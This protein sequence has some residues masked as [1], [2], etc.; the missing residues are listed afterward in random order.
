MLEKTGIGLSIFVIIIKGVLF[1][2]TQQTTAFDSAVN[3]IKTSKAIQTKAGVV[4]SVFLVP[5]GGLRMSTSSQ[6]SAGQ[7]NLNFIVKGSEKYIDLNLLMN[8]DVETD[9]Q[10]KIS[11]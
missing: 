11:E 6:G 10:I 3:F 7:A 5:L 9:W 8:K 2:A 4:N 1:F